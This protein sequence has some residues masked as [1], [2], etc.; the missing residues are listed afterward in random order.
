MTMDILIASIS[1]GVAVCA[2]AGEAIRT[3]RG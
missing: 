1:V 3:W 2:F